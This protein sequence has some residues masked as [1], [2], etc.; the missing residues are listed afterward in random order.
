MQYLKRS[1]NTRSNKNKK[2]ENE[3]QYF[4]IQHHLKT[5]ETQLTLYK[6]IRKATYYF[7]LS[8]R[9]H[10]IRP[11]AGHRDLLLVF[12]LKKYIR[13]Y[14]QVLCYLFIDIRLDET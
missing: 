2:Q 4:N 12:H 5:H 3:H 1:V 8:L 9:C 13:I 10:P 7:E 6:T 11:P 14:T